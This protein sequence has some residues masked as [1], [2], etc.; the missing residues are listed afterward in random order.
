MHN[1][2]HNNTL[3]NKYFVTKQASAYESSTVFE[4]IRTI[5]SQC[6]F[7]TKRY[8]THKNTHKQKS[9]SKTKIN[10]TKQQRQQFFA[11]TNF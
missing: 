3:N 11:Q 8:C 5:L 9:T 4:V 10:N 1:S 2:M 7:F 6:I